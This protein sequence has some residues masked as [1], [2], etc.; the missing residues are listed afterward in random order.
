MKKLVIIFLV[1]FMATPVFAAHEILEK[2]YQAAWC[3]ARGGIQEYRLDDGARVDCLLP[4]YAVEFDFGPKWAECCGQAIYYGQKT[5]RTP[6][7]VLIIEDA[8]NDAVF[9]ERL[10][11]TAT[12]AGVK[13]W[14]MTKV[15]LEMGVVNDPLP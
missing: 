10:R 9:I 2:E 8:E 5:N 12:K 3:N 6:A 1:L 13:W 15:D 14:T 7:C 4:E 11:I